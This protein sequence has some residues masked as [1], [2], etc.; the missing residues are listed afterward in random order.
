MKK[1]FHRNKICRIIFLVIILAYFL[2]F[3]FGNVISSV[4]LAV[5]Y[6]ESLDSE[7]VFDLFGAGCV[8]GLIISFFVFLFVFIFD[9]HRLFLVGVKCDSA[10]EVTE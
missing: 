5:N 7:V 8:F 4:K 9:L 10:P 1:K 6:M 2:L 3:L